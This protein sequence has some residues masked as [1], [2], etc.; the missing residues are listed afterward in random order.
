MPVPAKNILNYE[1]LFSES[2]YYIKFSSFKQFVDSPVC[3]QIQA[4]YIE[5]AE[6]DGGGLHNWCWGFWSD[7]FLEQFSLR[8]DE[9]L[10]V[11]LWVVGESVKDF[12]S[13]RLLPCFVVHLAPVGWFGH[14]GSP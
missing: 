11:F 9:L 14:G 6:L 3:L 12:C 4:V 7:L 10:L 5:G 1:L 2:L 8:S 13:L